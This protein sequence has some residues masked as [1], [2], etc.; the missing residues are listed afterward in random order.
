MFSEQSFRL[1]GKIAFVTGASYGIGFALASGFAMYGATIV[2]NDINAELVEKGLAA[3]R[4]AGIPAK[5]YVCDVTDEGQIRETVARSE[6]EG[7][8]VDVWGYQAG[9]FKRTPMIEMSVV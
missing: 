9:M 7:G 1:D 4:E 8:P 3:Y 2:F 5:G 6:K